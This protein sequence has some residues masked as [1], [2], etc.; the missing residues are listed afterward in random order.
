M[1]NVFTGAKVKEK[2]VVGLS[3]VYFLL[4][5][6]ALLGCLLLP[7]DNNTVMD[8]GLLYS[9]LVVLN[10][11]LIENQHLSK[12]AAVIGILFYYQTVFLMK[13]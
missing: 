10:K 6:V 11:A 1:Q 5:W 8:K 12:C 3:C 13:S 4:C 9:A 2:L 7:C